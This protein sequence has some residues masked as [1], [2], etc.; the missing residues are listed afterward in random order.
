MAVERNDG[1]HSM[2]KLTM[3]CLTRK[4]FQEILISHGGERLRLIVRELKGQAVRLV[5]EGPESFEIIRDDAKQ[6]SR[7]LGINRVPS[8]PVDTADS[9]DLE[10][11]LG[12][13]LGHALHCQRS[14][15]DDA[16]STDRHG[17]F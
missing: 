15:C 11:S 6:Q 10:G 3:L 16:S 17:D 4:A 8:T 9:T 5:F 1:T 2:E 7:K 14:H 13:S 12:G